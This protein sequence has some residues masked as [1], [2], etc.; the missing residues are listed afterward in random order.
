MDRHKS[1]GLIMITILLTYLKMV[2]PMW[3]PYSIHNYD[4]L[5][6]VHMMTVFDDEYIVSDCILPIRLVLRNSDSCLL[7]H[8]ENRKKEKN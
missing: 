5:L 3:N 4:N 2:W 7:D 6:I 1:D 8:P